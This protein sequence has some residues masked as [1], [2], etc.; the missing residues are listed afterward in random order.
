VGKPRLTFE[1][2]LGAQETSIHPGLDDL[3][4]TDVIM[5]HPALESFNQL[6]HCDTLFPEMVE[7]AHCAITSA[8]HTLPTP[9]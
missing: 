2:L 7:P 4:N 8:T 5:Q 6:Q 1:V 9:A 3:S